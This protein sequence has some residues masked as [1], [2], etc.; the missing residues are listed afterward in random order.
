MELYRVFISSLVKEENYSRMCL[1]ECKVLWFVLEKRRISFA[2][3][4]CDMEVFPSTMY[5]SVFVLSFYQSTHN[6]HK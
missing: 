5:V 1:M 6:I 3:M 4:R 2:Y